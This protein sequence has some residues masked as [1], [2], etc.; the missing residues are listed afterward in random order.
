LHRNQPHIVVL[1]KE[2]VA[3][4]AWPSNSAAAEPVQVL[5]RDSYPNP[6]R[7]RFDSFVGDFVVEDVVF[8]FRKVSDAFTH[9]VALRM[10]A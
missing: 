8:D 2:I 4:F 1:P 9:F 7:R 5:R 10:N 3:F 6:N